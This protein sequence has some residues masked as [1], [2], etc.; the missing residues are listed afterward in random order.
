MNIAPE[1]L[2][3]TRGITKTFPGVMALK[4]VGFEVRPGEILALVGEN[5]A[6]K[7]TLMNILSGYY[8]ADSGTIHYQGKEVR[9]RGIHEA[10]RAGISMIHQELSVATNL[11]IAENIL[12]GRY[13]RGP[14]GLVSPG[15]MAATCRPLM[16][17]LGL[18]DLDPAQKLATLNVS[19]RQLV[20]IAKALSFDAKLLIMDEPTSSLTAHETNYL[21]EIIRS[22]SKNGVSVIYISHRLDEVFALADRIL[23]LRD[24]M[25]AGEVTRAAMDRNTVISLMVG[26]ELQSQ[27][28]LGSETIREEF[29]L[30][31][32][33]IKWLPKVVDASFALR[34]GEILGF[35]GLV[36]SGRSELMKAVFGAVKASSG[37]VLLEGKAVA[38]TNPREAIS[39]GIGFVPE[40]RKEQ[41]LF[42]GM[43]VMENMSISVLDRLRS[44]LFVSQKRETECVEGFVE[45]LR[46]KT[47]SL[48]AQIRNLSGGNQQKAIIARWLL[49]KPK[50]L[51]LDEPTHGVDIGAK[52]EI[53][54]IMRDLAREGVSIILISSELTEILLMSDRVAVM[55]QGKV[56]AVLPREGLSS[57]L[58]MKYAVL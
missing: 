8:L 14:S 18:G 37:T 36:G 35:A 27:S 20:E 33:N 48:S 46:I 49:T 54:R 11:S 21:F 43:T 42:L 12:L 5:G 24:G 58:I 39:S 52:V 56:T 34:R 6:G 15:E 23:V 32:Q 22:L 45:K 17:R 3:E 38:F 55:N 9:F 50:V 1:L 7:S 16:E 51:I 47:P 57:E 44:S 30:E 26:R 53:Y 28:Y 25:V 31:A 10:Q 4:N 2:L 19:Q 40:D 41:S 13:K 29:V